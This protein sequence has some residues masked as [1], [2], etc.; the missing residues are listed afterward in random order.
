MN[1]LSISPIVSLIS[2]RV[3]T[4]TCGNVP[5]QGKWPAS[6]FY[7]WAS[8]A[9][10]SD[11]DRVPAGRMMK[12]REDWAMEETGEGRGGGEWGDSTKREVGNGRRE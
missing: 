1:V 11:I 12:Q 9:R 6:W 2:L 10:H 7:S 5:E 8:W 4:H 3:S